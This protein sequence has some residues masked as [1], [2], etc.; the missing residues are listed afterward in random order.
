MAVVYVEIF[1]IFLRILTMRYIH[2]VIIKNCKVQKQVLAV[3]ISVLRHRVCVYHQCVHCGYL[4]VLFQHICPPP[5]YNNYVYL[6]LQ[7][8]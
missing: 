3:S 1:T 6:L 2:T 7:T 4:V 5:C 8:S